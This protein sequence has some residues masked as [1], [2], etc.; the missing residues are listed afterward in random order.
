MI[1]KDNIAEGL[2][3]LISQHS[4]TELVMGAAA[5]KKYSKYV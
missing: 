5:D 3:S 2:I 4:V 1:E